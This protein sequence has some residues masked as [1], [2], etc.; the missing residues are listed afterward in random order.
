[1]K[2]SPAPPM[3]SSAPSFTMVHRLAHCASPLKKWVTSKQPLKGPPTTALPVESPLTLSS[4]N[5][6]RRSTYVCTGSATMFAKAN[7]QFCGAKEKLIVPITSSNINRRL[8]IK[9]FYPRISF[10]RQILPENILIVS[11]TPAPRH[12]HRRHMPIHSP[13][14]PRP[15]GEGV[16]LAA[17]DVMYDV[18]TVRC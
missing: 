17:S 15:P 16:L 12:P 18:T 1:M 14:F 5:D 11:P 6:Q 13:F 8:I 2:S 10:R 4:K 9:Q 3:P 7:S